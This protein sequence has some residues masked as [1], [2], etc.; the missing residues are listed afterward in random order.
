MLRSARS[1]LWQIRTHIRLDDGR[2]TYGRVMWSEDQVR[3]EKC[4]PAFRESTAVEAANR[5]AELSFSLTG[6]RQS[7]ALGKVPRFGGK[8][9]FT[10]LYFVSVPIRTKTPLTLELVGGAA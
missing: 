2:N 1:Y 7:F 10:G 3:I 8:R 9:R 4:P 6:K 5:L